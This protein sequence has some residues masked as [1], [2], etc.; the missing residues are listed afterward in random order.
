MLQVLA[1]TPDT[2]R[3]YVVGLFEP[4]LDGPKRGTVDVAQR[5]RLPFEALSNSQVRVILVPLPP[6]Q[7]RAADPE[8]TRPITL[9]VAQ[10]RPVKERFDCSGVMA[11]WTKLNWYW[12]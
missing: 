6:F 12:P 9:E 8:N 1:Q 5:A 4:V 7:R 2:L 3:H 11:R 10:K